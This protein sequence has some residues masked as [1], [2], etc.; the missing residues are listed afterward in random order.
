MDGLIPFTSLVVC[1]AAT[2]VCVAR[3]CGARASP[4]DAALHAATAGAAVVVGSMMIAGAAGRLRF[5][6]VLLLQLGAAA[7]AVIVSRHTQRGPLANRA[8]CEFPALIVAGV[9][10]LVAF[11]CAFAIWHAPLT[12]YDSLSYHLHFAAR[13]VQDQ[14]IAIVPTPFSDEAQAYA[15]ANGELFLAW[16]MLPFHADTLARMGQLPFALFGALAVYGIARRLDRR[17]SQAIYP[18]ALFLFARPIVEQMVGANVDLICCAFFAATVYF[19]MV[20]VDD[21]RPRNWAIAGVSAGLY[22]GT[23]YLALV[24]VPVLVLVACARGLRRRA[25]WTFPGLLAF[26]FPWYARNWI[27]AGSPIYPST[28][29]IAGFTVARGAFTRAA[30]LNTVFHTSDVRL[31]APMAAHA[32]GPALFIAWLP[33][34]AAGWFAMLRRGWWPTGALA[35]VPLLMVPLYWFGFPVN[36]DSRFLMPAVGPALLPVAFVF[37]GRPGRDRWIHGLLAAAVVWVVVGARRSLPAA[38]PWFMSGWLSLNGLI[39]PAFLPAF[40]AIAG[41]LALLWVLVRRAPRF[42]LPAFTAAVACM[43]A[44]LAFGAT[45]W[46]RPGTCTYL[47][48]T[49]PS[50]RTGYF[51]SWHWIDEHIAGATVAYTGINLPYPL[52]GERL[53][54]RVVYVNIDGRAHW[55]FHDYDR[56][57]RSGRFTPDP[58]VLAESSGELL[59]VAHR[60]GPRDDAVRPR[61]ERMQGNR[62]AWIFALEQTRVEY[63]FVAMLS[64]YEIDYVWH[65]DRGFPIEEEWARQDPVRFHLVY[66]NPLVRIYAFDAAARARG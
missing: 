13:W 9:G 37:S 38:L 65:D 36:I 23:K 42:A 28:L 18:A 26:A 14:R 2:G 3:R 40:A 35:A 64:A 16:L 45:R 49:S 41:G 56:G 25:L 20:A 39:P 51:D 5:A 46:C 30:M 32:I 47:D 7:V 63:L 34:A 57:Y 11:A 19:L 66:T 12:L 52:T 22:L 15:P 54:N 31:L 21:D 44:T 53:A 1:V 24:Y 29:T 8:V 33:C 27:V 50:I 59:P 61:Y 48:T 62:D 4:A 60:T 17:A 58:P 6:D 55:R 43:T 10:T